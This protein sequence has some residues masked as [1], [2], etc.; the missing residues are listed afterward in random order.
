MAT[1]L[2]PQKNQF[3]YQLPT[4][5]VPNDI[6]TKYKSFLTREHSMYNN[7]VDY[8]NSAIMG[9]DIPSMNFPTVEQNARY[10]KKI[11]FRGGTAPYDTFTRDFKI[12]F[13]AVDNFMNY[14]ILQDIM[15][16]H[17]I[18]V[19]AIFVQPFTISILDKNRD[20]MFK[21]VLREITVTGL[22]GKDLGYEKTDQE[23]DTFDLSFVANFI[24]WEY[25]GNKTTP[26]LI[27][28]PL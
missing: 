18:N 1:G 5:F 22:V 20:E 8:L 7:I 27:K 6:E 24:D 2:N 9:V 4:D 16:F 26:N 19:D 21:Y 10:G 23:F 14:F 25:V 3:V 15:M 28:I 13:K 12:R 17:Y 11:N